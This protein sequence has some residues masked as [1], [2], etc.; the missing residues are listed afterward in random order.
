LC[1]SIQKHSKR[2]IDIK[3]LS[4]ESNPPIDIQ[5][6]KRERE[7]AKNLPAATIPFAWPAAFYSLPEL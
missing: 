2:G 5:I 6:T 4:E 3:Q 1:S 7:S